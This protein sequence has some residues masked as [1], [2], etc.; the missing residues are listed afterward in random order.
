[1]KKLFAL[2]LISAFA[3]TNTTCK[4]AK[5]EADEITEFDINYSSQ[6]SV[7]SQTMSVNVPVDFTTPNIPTNSSTNLASNKTTQSLVDFIKMSKFKI[8][9]GAGNLDFLKSLQIFVKA[10]NMS[11]TLVASK[12]SI[13]TGIT[14]V[15]ADLPD[16]NI[17]DYIFQ[18]NIQFRVSVVIDG[19]TVAGQTLIMDETVHVKA[20]II[21]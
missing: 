19:S 3:F 9:V 14:T 5:E 4:K 2:L 17:K 12:T 18:Q 15:D 20:T 6:I 13:P 10:N 21:K 11:E 7:P 16:V 1:M 8:S